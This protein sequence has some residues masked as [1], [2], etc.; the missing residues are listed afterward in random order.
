MA[1]KSNRINRQ[2]NRL[3]KNST[4]MSVQYRATNIV[5]Q[6]ITNFVFTQEIT[7]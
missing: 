1:V 3:N 2:S 4:R 7:N 5:L 6:E